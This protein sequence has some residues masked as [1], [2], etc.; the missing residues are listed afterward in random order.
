MRKMKD[1][2]IPW[3]GEIPNSWNVF[4]VKNIAKRKSDKNRPDKQ[5]LSLYRE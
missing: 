2:G 4:K 3:L 5:V 1:S